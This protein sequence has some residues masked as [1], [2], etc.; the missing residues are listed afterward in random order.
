MPQAGSALQKLHSSQGRPALPHS[1]VTS[2]NNEEA[3]TSQRA[4][5]GSNQGN[6]F[7]QGRKTLVIAIDK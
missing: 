4:E 2:E 6:L 5:A 7:S 3:R 1:D